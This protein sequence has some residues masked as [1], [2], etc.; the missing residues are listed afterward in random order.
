MERNGLRILPF[1]ILSGLTEVNDTPR[2]PPNGSGGLKH[3]HRCD[4]AVNLPPALNFSNHHP[5]LVKWWLED[6]GKSVGEC[7][8]GNFAEVLVKGTHLG[9]VFAETI[10][11]IIDRLSMKL[12]YGFVRIGEMAEPRDE[13]EV[14]DSDT[15]VVYRIWIFYEEPLPFPIAGAENLTTGY[16]NDIILDERRI[17]IHAAIRGMVDYRLD[18][19]RNGSSRRPRRTRKRPSQHPLASNSGR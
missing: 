13:E 12:G 7:S 19:P 16:L 9:H 14:K 11:R 5:A 2:R 1:Q 8:E 4:L 17:N 6:W 15:R 10:Y 3:Y 18:K